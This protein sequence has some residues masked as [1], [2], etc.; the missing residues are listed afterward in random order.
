MNKKLS[1]CDFFNGNLK[2]E[3]GS[4]IEIGTELLSLLK[5]LFSR[6]PKDEPVQNVADQNLQ[7]CTL[8]DYVN[9]K[10][11]PVEQAVVKELQ[12]YGK[13]LEM[14]NQS[15]AHGF[16]SKHKVSTKGFSQQIDLLSLQIPGVITSEVSRHLSDSDAEFYRIRRMLPG[17]EKNAA[18]QA[19]TGRVIQDAVEKSALLAEQIID[20][21]QMQFFSL[22]QEELERSQQQL[23]RKEE[24][25]AALRIAAG[26]IVEQTKI[27]EQAQH[28][29]QCCGLVESL[30]R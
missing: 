2:P 28:I 25:L 26:D 22:L 15:E 16:F 11:K 19:F 30:L 8:C 12:Q 7:L 17:S 3:F 27:K 4:F 23:E 21:I 9:S 24:E 10:A 1:L 5:I 20:A 29:C 18:M 14:L 6:P 13:Y